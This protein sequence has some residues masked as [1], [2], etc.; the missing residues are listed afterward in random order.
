MRIGAQLRIL[1][2][3]ERKPCPLSL[4][5]KHLHMQT[6]LVAVMCPSCSPMAD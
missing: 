5:V 4:S 1:S 2:E 3:R 6:L